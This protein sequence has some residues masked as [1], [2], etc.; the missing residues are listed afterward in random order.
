MPFVRS[1]WQCVP[2]VILGE[3][4]VSIGTPL[5]PSRDLN[6][7]STQDGALDGDLG[8]IDLIRVLTHGTRITQSGFGCRR[9]GFFVDRLARERLLGGGRSPWD[10]RDRTHH[11][12]G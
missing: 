9:G 4:S 11:N 8:D 6:A 2:T 7:A 12:A 10:G 1:F 5:R 3:I